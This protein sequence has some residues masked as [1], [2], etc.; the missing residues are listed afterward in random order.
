MLLE[1]QV[2]NVASSIHM[3]I[4]SFCCKFV[5]S[6]CVRH[7]KTTDTHIF[8]L[9]FFFAGKSADSKLQSP[10]APSRMVVAA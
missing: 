2:P 4:F 7:D 6:F 10:G 8:F 5:V 9:H 1:S 3:S